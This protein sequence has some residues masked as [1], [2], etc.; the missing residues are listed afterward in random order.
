MTRL[1]FKSYTA[2]E[3]AAYNAEHTTPHR[4]VLVAMATEAKLLPV[5]PKRS[6]NRDEEILEHKMLHGEDA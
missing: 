2:A 1:T 5:R 6:T 4:K 3:I